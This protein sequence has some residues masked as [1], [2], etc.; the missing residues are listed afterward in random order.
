MIRKLSALPIVVSV[1]IGIDG[2]FLV[3]GAQVPP[4]TLRTEADAAREASV[5]GNGV[6]GVSWT[7][8]LTSRL[9]H[10]GELAAPAHADRLLR[11]NPGQLRMITQLDD[12]VR[13]GVS[14]SIELEAATVAK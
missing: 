14:L 3:W 11:L 4:T 9:A 5:P 7:M 8:R 13:Q 1:L 6:F 12:L 2:A 10:I